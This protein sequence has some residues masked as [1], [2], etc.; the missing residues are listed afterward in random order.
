MGVVLLE[1][2]FLEDLR[3]IAAWYQNFLIIDMGVVY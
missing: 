1:K 2:Y 3:W